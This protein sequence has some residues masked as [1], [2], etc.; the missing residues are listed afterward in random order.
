ML[1]NRRQT[2]KSTTQLRRLA[3][4]GLWHFESATAASLEGVKLAAFGH[5]TSPGP[6]TLQD[7]ALFW[8]SL[9]KPFC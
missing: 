2:R 5:Q 3:N 8:P 7:S 6:A 1:L 9:A 4:P